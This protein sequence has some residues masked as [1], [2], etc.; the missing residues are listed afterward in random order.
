MNITITSMAIDGREVP[1][2]V[3]LS[4]LVTN[5]WVKERN[6]C[7]LM[8]EYDREVIKRDGHLVTRLTKREGKK[9]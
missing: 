3:G 9:I 7:E 8:Q 5:C 2:P 4:E 6:P 1:V